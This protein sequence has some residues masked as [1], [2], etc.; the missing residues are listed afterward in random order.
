MEKSRFFNSV[1]SSA[2]QSREASKTAALNEE[3]RKQEKASRGSKRYIK[4]TTRSCIRELSKTIEQKAAEGK[5][6]AWVSR[7]TRDVYEKPYLRSA[8][9]QAGQH[10]ARQGFVATV[11][12]HDNSQD[13]GS[14][15]WVGADRW[16]VSL[17]VSWKDS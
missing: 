17:F 8:L 7:D 3:A 12:E 11:G 15:G 10:F 13:M 2:E 5:D 1:K 16:T 4:R 9:D 6:K 14:M